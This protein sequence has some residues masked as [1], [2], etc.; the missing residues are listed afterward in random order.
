LTGISFLAL[1]DRGTDMTPLVK[2]PSQPYPIIKTAPSLFLRMDTALT[3][4]SESLRS[5]STSISSVLDKDN[6]RQI[7]LTIQNLQQ[8]TGTLAHDSQYMTTI[9]QNTAKASGQ[10]TPFLNNLNTQTLPATNQMMINLDSVID[11]LSE[12][13]TELKQ[14]PSILIRGKTSQPLGPGEQ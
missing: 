9:L 5:V 11:N 6:V 1:K 3:Q 10:F 7:K 4:L 12:V 13:S 14:N 2:L 8:L